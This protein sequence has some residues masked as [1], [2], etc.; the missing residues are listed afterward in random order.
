MHRADRASS[1]GSYGMAAMGCESAVLLCALGLRFELSLL[2]SVESVES[3]TSRPMQPISRLRLRFSK[4]R[5][6]S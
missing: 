4:F 3:P 2:H 6:T 5:S 1:Y